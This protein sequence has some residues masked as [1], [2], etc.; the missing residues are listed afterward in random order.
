[1]EQRKSLPFP[2]KFYT[3]P[4]LRGSSPCYCRERKSWCRCD[5]V[6]LP[7]VCCKLRNKNLM[8]LS[9]TNI[10]IHEQKISVL[11]HLNH[12]CSTFFQNW[13]LFLWWIPFGRNN[14]WVILV[15]FYS[16]K[17][18]FCYCIE[19]ST[20]SLISNC[21]LFFDI[22]YIWKNIFVRLCKYHLGKEQW[23]NAFQP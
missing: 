1:M 3:A 8:K 22:T 23:N 13:P 11:G 7:T 17:F 20:L 14:F 18:M 12:A 9:A 19:K 4:W 5:K 6:N 10:F 15:I 21:T 2:A 16:P